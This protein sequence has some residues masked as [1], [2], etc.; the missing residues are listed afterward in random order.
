MEQPIDRSRLGPLRP[1]PV[2]RGIPAGRWFGI[3]VRLDPS[4]LLIFGLITFTLHSSFRLGHPELSGWPIWTAALA[5]SLLFFTSILLHELSHSVV[6]KALG[7]EV[8]GIVLFMFGGI[9][10]LK[11]EPR[12][13]SEEA[14]ISVVGPFTS[15][16]L[17]GIFL[18]LQLVLPA[19]SIT[20]DVLS[21]LGFINLMLAAFNLLPGL[22]LDG[23]R[24]LR[25]GVWAATG[26]R[27]RA[28]RVAAGM[29]SLIAVLLMSLGILEILFIPAAML[30][31]LWLVFIGWFLLSSARQSR[32]ALDVRGLLGTLRVDQVMR[33]DCVVVSPDERLDRLVDDRVLRSGARCYLVSRE[34]SFE[35]LITLREIGRVPRNEWDRTVVAEAMVPATD[36]R[37]LQRDSSL[38]DA[39]DLMEGAGVNQIPVVE[40]GR[41]V[42]M[43]T[44]ED[45]MHAM[46]VQ[47]ELG[48]SEAS[49]RP[50]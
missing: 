46:A 7:L 1:P 27:A 30:G 32:L 9:S 3:D 44:R 23:G 12:K 41:L 37:S 18:L 5:G 34:G 38:A 31:G 4:W 8:H 43:V 15:A 16:V 19:G 20:R 29:G 2:L 25:A 39:F 13:A 48:P 6:A 22:P 21:W 45:L 49:G 17:G 35:G 28:T 10:G 36:V 47:A 11:G 50:A 26:D 33:N 24:L 40:D 14:V 42:G